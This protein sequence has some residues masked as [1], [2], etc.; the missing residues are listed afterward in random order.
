MSSNLE[1]WDELQTLARGTLE[2]PERY[3]DLWLALAPQIERWLASSTFLGRVA[4]QPEWQRDILLLVWEKLQDREL[5]KLAAFFRSDPQQAS[6]AAKHPFRAWMRRVVKNVGIDYLRSLPEYIR[7][8]KPKRRSR[9]QSTQAPSLAKHWHSIASLHSMSGGQREPVTIENTARQ[10]LE[11]L[12]ATIP[13]RLR[14]AAE[15]FE[16]N[17]PLDAIASALG[18]R[19]TADAERLICRAQDRLAYRAA[20][21]LWSQGYSDDDIADQLDLSD[22][23]HAQRLIKAAKEMLRRHFRDS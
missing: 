5:A 4:D 15:L 6:G 10:L 20:I 16:S 11:F 3:T 14:R 19:S 8:R 22:T 21:E 12:D 1:D 13:D 23:Q 7:R 17:E 9:T 18:V 2:Q